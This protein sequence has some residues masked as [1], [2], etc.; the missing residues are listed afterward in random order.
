M[1]HDYSETTFGSDFLPTEADYTDPD[2]ARSIHAHGWMIW[3]LIPYHYDT[4]VK[5]LPTRPRL[6]LTGGT[7]WARTTWRGMCWRA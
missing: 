2:V 3:P 7:G 5:N 6:R 1:L 4:I